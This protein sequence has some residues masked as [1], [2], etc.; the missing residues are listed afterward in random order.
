[1]YDVLQQYL[2]VS[3][4]E[5]GAFETSLQVDKLDVLDVARKEVVV[6]HL[7]TNDWYGGLDGVALVPDRRV[8]LGRVLSEVGITSCAATF[9]L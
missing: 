1:M 5:I 6:L 3:G 2:L 4:G 8:P 9:E 7:A